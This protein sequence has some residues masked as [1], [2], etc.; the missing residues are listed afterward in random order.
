[1][2]TSRW[3]SSGSPPRRRSTS[4]LT[5]SNEPNRRRRVTRR[6]CRVAEPG[7]RQRRRAAGIAR[8][9][10]R[11]SAP[12]WL[13][14]RSKQVDTV[15]SRSLPLLAITLIV[16]DV[17]DGSNSRLMRTAN[18]GQRRRRRPR[19]SEDGR[20]R[21]PTSRHVHDHDKSCDRHISDLVPLELDRGA[22][23]RRFHLRRT[24]RTD[25]FR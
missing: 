5:A 10:R 1:M 11:R 25:F 14:D 6:D 23:S 7:S 4:E 15:P 3:N 22:E 9:T 16:L 8:R 17:I 13:P 20:R 24:K 2:P 12:A 18:V 21:P 19:R